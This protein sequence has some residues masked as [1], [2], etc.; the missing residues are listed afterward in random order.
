[1]LESGSF[2]KQSSPASRALCE[3]E[4][5]TAQHILTICVF[6]RQ[7]WHNQLAPAGL[8][9]MVP[10]V[11]EINL[12]VY[13][14][15]KASRRTDKAK[16]KGFNSMVTLGAWTLWIQRNRCVYDGATPS[17][18]VAQC[19]S[20]GAKVSSMGTGGKGGWVGRS[21]WGVSLINPGLVVTC[22]SI[23]Q[24]LFVFFP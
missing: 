19:F 17:L 1:M 2:S 20:W 3:Q 5:E 11:N 9:R 18:H 7:F 12:Y 8:G 10:R 22:F 14:W 4:D 21:C 23:F 16:W 15:R 6:V 13:W 24:V